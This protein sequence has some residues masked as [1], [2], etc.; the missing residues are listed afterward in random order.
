MQILVFLGKELVG[1]GGGRARGRAWKR[2]RRLE[3][4]VS[5]LSSVEKRLDGKISFFR[6]SGQRSTFHRRVSAARNRLLRKQEFALAP[7]LERLFGGGTYIAGEHR[8]RDVNGGEKEKKKR[9]KGVKE[10]EGTGVS[11]RGRKAR[12]V[13]LC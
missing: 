5:R 2:A 9:R 4:N 1:R 7:T 13:G 6:N 8:K 11:T 3:A 12:G 10:R